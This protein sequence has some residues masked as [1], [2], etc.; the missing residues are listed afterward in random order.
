VEGRPYRFDFEFKSRKLAGSVN[1]SMA[2]VGTTLGQVRGG[3]KAS[4][5]DWL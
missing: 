4:P 3:L 1:F 2:I 5:D